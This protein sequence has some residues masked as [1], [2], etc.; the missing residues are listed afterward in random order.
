MKK[1]SLFLSALIIAFVSSCGKYG[2][3]EPLTGTKIEE[4]INAY[5][6]LRQ[7]AP[8]LLNN[9][10]SGDINKQKEGFSGFESELKK[11]N[12]S[13]P[14]FVRLNAKIGAIYSL[15][16]A[17]NFMGDM[18][19][20]KTGGI[21][22]MDEG[23]K[24]IQQQIDDP[25][26]PAEAKVELKKS[27]EEMKSAKSKVN[28]EYGNNKYWADLVMD[29]TKSIT[30]QFVSKEDVELVK[31]YK[32]KITEAYAGTVPTSFNVNEENLK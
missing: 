4:Y 10:N 7:N 1:Y 28:T 30:N 26:V 19:K 27:L 14:E 3:N 9:A 6:G 18:E 31:S 20:M 13:Y 8:S 5:K 12:L 24:Q 16:S 17:E 32:D 11:N 21:E 23:M 15:I 22:Q 2:N 25:N 29:K